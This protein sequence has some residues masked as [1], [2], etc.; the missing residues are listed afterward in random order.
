MAEQDIIERVAGAAVDTGTERMIARKDGAI[1]WL[2][3]N[4]PARRNA[5]SVDMWAAIPKA[6]SAFEA[7]PAI[8]AV[9]LAGAGDKAFVSGADISQFE[10]VR[11]NPEDNEEYKAVSGGGQA[12]ISRLTKPSIAMIKGFCIGGGLAVA[13]SCDLRIAAEGSRFAI[14]AAKLGLGYNY[15]GLATLASIVGPAYARE[16]MFT[17][18][19]FDGEEALRMGLINRLVP[20]A[21]LENTV[22]DYAGMIGANAPLTVKAAK[23]AVNEFVKDEARRDIAKV[24]A[25]VDAC[26]ASADY[27]EG[28]KAFM[29]KRAPNF[30]GK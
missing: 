14:P 12:A 1:G 13:L 18:R 26:F 4:N 25:A 11:A 21:D 23:M 15:A 16:I 28:R 29:E 2:I 24:E 5:V 6:L 17:A 9:V 27:A 7:D 22:R 10:N 19:Q 8:R 30:Q 20:L 3:F